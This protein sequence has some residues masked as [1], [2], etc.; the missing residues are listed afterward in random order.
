VR[1]SLS[2]G[3]PL[4]HH[5]PANCHASMLPKQPETNNTHTN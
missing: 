1:P 3:K 2:L 5:L 4:H